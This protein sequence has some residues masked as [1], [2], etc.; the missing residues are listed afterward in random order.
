MKKLISVILALITLTVLLA[1][2]GAKPESGAD[3]SV[4]ASETEATG[5]Q[6][7]DSSIILGTWFATT[8]VYNGEEYNADDLFN[9]TFLLLFKD[10]GECRMQ[11]NDEWSVV[12]WEL[13][14][15]GVTLKGEDTYELT[16]T[17][18]NK[19]KLL[20]D[21]NGADVTLEKYEEE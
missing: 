14:D 2:C 12:T 17:D 6:T 15:S 16:F 21:I 7:T 4:Q 13:S 1:A 11:H 3:E 19:N 9:G 10:N 20:M 5:T 8:A 18:E